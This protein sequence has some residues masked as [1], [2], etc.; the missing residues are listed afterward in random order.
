MEL[1]FTANNN[2][3]YVPLTSITIENLTR[4]CDTTLQA[5]DTV[6]SFSYVGIENHNSLQRDRLYLSQNYPNPFE[7]QTSLSVYVPDQAKV[8]LATYNFL[9]IRKALYTQTLSRGHHRFTFFP[10]NDRIYILSAS[11]SGTTRA[12]RMTNLGLYPASNCRIMYEGRIGTEKIIESYQQNAGFIYCPRDMLKFTGH[13]ATG[14]SVLVDIPSGNYTYVFQFAAGTAC[15]SISTVTYEGQTYNTV[16][17]GNQCWLSENLN[18]GTTKNALYN[19]SDDGYMEKYCYDNLASN[20]AIYGGLYQ[21]DEMMQYTTQPGVQGICPPGWHLPVDEE[22]CI[23]ENELDATAIDCDKT[24]WRGTNSGGKLKEAGIENWLSPNTGATNSSG[25]KALPGSYRTTNGYFGDI[26][27]SSGYYWSSSEKDTDSAWLRKLG[28]TSERA[29]RDAYGKKAGFSVRCTKLAGAPIIV[30]SDITIIT[31]STA[32]GGGEITSQGT[33]P[34]TAR[35]VCWSTSKN[36]TVNDAHTVDGSGPGPFVSEIKVLTPGYTYYVRAYATNQAE[37]AYGE[38]R[39]IATCPG[40][41]FFTYGGQ[42][43]NTVMIG[44]QCWLKENLNIG[45]MITN[46]NQTNNGIIE[47]YCYENIQ[48]NCVIYGGLYQWNEMMQFVTTPGVKG[49]CPDGWHLPTDGE[50]CVLEQFVDPTV[51]CYSNYWR[52]TDGGGKLKEAGNMH[53]SPPNLG[54]SNFSNFTALPGGGGGYSYFYSLQDA[55]GFW[56]SNEID[57]KAWY[58]YLKHDYKQVYRDP[59]IKGACLS[60]RCLKD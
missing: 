4:G 33:F 13:S 55:G 43:Y 56:T 14:M 41:S 42:V 22:W 10:G 48:A 51:I 38:Q 6:L 23:L 1:T 25:F 26:P 17:I 59:C 29:W 53:W 45:T 54:A 20:C 15:P 3:E 30:T 35:G 18:V 58:R 21:W 32:L 34:V 24:G 49:I 37:T 39:L 50:W 12:I 28:H 57:T 19:Q 9:G 47:K 52:G 36:P 2:G 16:V 46:S 60:V 5:P 44:T 7:E 27:G 40:I 11:C 31:D 8:I